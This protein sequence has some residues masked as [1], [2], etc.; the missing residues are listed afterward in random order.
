[1]FV[2]ATGFISFVVIAGFGLLF[3]FVAG[4]GFFL[5]FVSVCG[6]FLFVLS[7]SGFCLRLDL[8]R[9]FRLGLVHVRR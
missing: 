8:V 2:E 9:P 4:F 5:I 1:L 6:S 7:G 3:Y